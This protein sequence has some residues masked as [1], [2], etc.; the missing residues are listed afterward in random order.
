[1]KF[2]CIFLMMFRER[3]T[4]WRSCGTLEVQRVVCIYSFFMD[5]RGEGSAYVFEWRKKIT[6]K[7]MFCFHHLICT[8]DYCRKV[9]NCIYSIK[10]V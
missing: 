5:M 9:M 8:E 2:C 3:R 7:K 6:R 1:M 10:K 4:C